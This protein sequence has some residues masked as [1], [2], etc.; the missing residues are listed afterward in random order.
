MTV[1]LDRWNISAGRKL[2]DQIDKFIQ[3]EGESDA[4]M[5]YATTNSLGSQPCRE[6]YAYALAR[7]LDTRGDEFPVSGL[8]PASVDPT[9]IPAGIRTRLHV[10]LTDP[11][12][13][14]RIVA[15]VEGRSANLR[16]TAV[17]PFFMKI[18]EYPFFDRKFAIEIRPRAGTWSPFMGG[19]LSVE[20]DAVRPSI[21]RGPTNRP[22]EGG[23]LHMTSQGEDNR[24]GIW[25]IC[26]AQDEATPTQSYYLFCDRLPSQIIFG[27]LDSER[28]FTIDLRNFSA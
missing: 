8:F 23:V 2:W 26:S 7:A 12:W 9:L 22:Q 4:W 6:E 18:H 24:G 5:I 13:K 1:K 14:E 17:A 16:K 27:E 20:K 19:V 15:A 11:E 25:W 10:S 21:Q 3:N 28:Q